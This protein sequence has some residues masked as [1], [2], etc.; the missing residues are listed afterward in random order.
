M[1]IQNV[2]YKYKKILYRYITNLIVDGINDN[3]YKF[4]NLIVWYKFI[5]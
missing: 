3:I 2:F 1:N 5:M 4:V